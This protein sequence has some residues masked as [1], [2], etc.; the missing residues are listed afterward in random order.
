M[1]LHVRTGISNYAATLEKRPIRVSFRFNGGGHGTYTAGPLPLRRSAL[2]LYR[3]LDPV[4][5]RQSTGLSHD[6]PALSGSSPYLLLY[7]VKK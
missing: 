2:P 5:I 7:S 1:M 6:A 3:Q 4:A